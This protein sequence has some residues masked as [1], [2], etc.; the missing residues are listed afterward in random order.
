MSHSV[1]RYKKNVLTLAVSSLLLSQSISGHAA[2]SNKPKA[3]VDLG[4]SVVRGHLHEHKHIYSE[5]ITQKSNHSLGNL[6]SDNMGINAETFGNTATRPIIRGQV[7]ERVTVLSNGVT[8]T[9]A[10]SMSPDHAIAIN[11]LAANDIE[12]LRGPDALAFGAN[13]TT[14]VIDVRDN[15]IVT[16]QPDSPFSGSIG[17][18]ASSVDNGVVMFANT[19]FAPNENWVF[20]FSGKRSNSQ[21]Y[22]IPRYLKAHDEHDEEH[23]EHHDED[24]HHDEHEEAHEGEHHDKKHEEHGAGAKRVAGSYSKEDSIG[25]GINWLGDRMSVGLSYNEEQKKYGLPGHVHNECEV[26]TEDDGSVELH[27]E[28]H[29]HEEEHAEGE[30]HHEEE[31][32]E[33]AHDHENEPPPFIVMNTK[34]YALAAQYRPLGF[35]NQLDAKV[36]YT[37]YQHD[38]YDDGEVGTTYTN[39]GINSRISAKHKPLNNGSMF[40]EFGMQFDKTKFAAVG[41]ESY[42]PKTDTRLIALYAKERYQPTKQWHI[43]LA[44]RLEKKTLDTAAQS[45]D[46]TGVSFATEGVWHGNNNIRYGMTLSHSQRLPNAVELFADGA[47]IATN[48]IERGNAELDAEKTTGLEL[49]AKKRKGD[50]Q[51]DGSIF[52]NHVADYIYAKTLAE[53]DGVRLV[54]YTQQDANLYGGE[55]SASYTFNP[56]FTLMGYGD[57]VR[58]ELDKAENGNKN[59]PR[60][61][62]AR[63][64]VKFINDLG[65]G[66]ETE[67]DAY[68]RFRQKN[69]AAFEENTRSYNMVNAKVRYTSD[70]D[71]SVSVYVN[72]NNLTNTEAFNHT[73]FIKEA[74]PLPSRNY[75]TGIELKF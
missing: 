45:K 41:E 58:G 66:W 34:S 4:S 24:E 25:L 46:F 63:A 73:S 37:D 68:H 44:G 61:P 62:A 74:A 26:E 75:M 55:L 12:I 51:F 9:D 33:E 40:G 57:I 43:D 14:G 2:E 1:V 36:K 11:T 30:N 70:T 29:E 10:S 8:Q 16:V 28:E 20:S 39:T 32:H 59:I 52:Y 38:E 72:A 23:E 22:D 15:L 3:V 50:W 49:S 69:Y 35:F 67:V 31:G 13:A 42:V 6:L 64:G 19:L 60:M 21:D 17:G 48:T 5:D 65:N 56:Y 47:H 71:P 53:N 7:G 18:Q 54:N 27:C